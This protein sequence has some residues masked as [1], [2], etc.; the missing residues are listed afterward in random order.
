MRCSGP[1]SAAAHHENHFLSLWAMPRPSRDW[2]DKPDLGRFEKTDQRRIL[3]V[4]PQHF[5]RMMGYE[6]RVEVLE[7]L[8]YFPPHDLH[9]HHAHDQCRPDAGLP[10]ICN[11]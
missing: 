11:E 2:T 5:L 3:A 1:F 8:L 9:M 4:C 6:N 10:Q 7:R